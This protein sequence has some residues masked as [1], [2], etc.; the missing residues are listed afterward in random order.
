ML[1]RQGPSSYHRIEKKFIAPALKPWQKDL[2]RA[3]QQAGPKAGMIFTVKSMRQIGK[4]FVVNIILLYHALTYKKSNSI[5]VSITYRNCS[6]MFEEICEGLNGFQGLDNIDKMSMTIKFTNGS[7]ITYMSAMSRENLRG[8][9]VKNGGILCIDEAAYL[10]EDIFGIVFPFVNVSNANILMVSTPRLKQGSYYDYYQAGFDDSIE[11][12]KS[13]NWSTYD[14]SE[15][16]TPERVDMYRKLLPQSQFVSEVL[17][18]FVDDIAGVFDLKDVWYSAPKF[19]KSN[20][21]Q[22]IF[23]GI[24]WSSGKG[25]DFT[26]I[27]GFDAAGN[28]ILLEYFNDKSPE[29]QL[30]HISHLL[31]LLDKDKIRG[32]NCETNS[33]GN[34]Y[35]DRL[36]IIMPGF[37]IYEFTT[38]NSS[39]REIV[40][41]LASRCGE[42]TIRLI[43]DPEQ[44]AQMSAYQMQ[45]TKSGLTTYNSIGAHDDIC[46]A[47]SMAM[48]LIKDKLKTGGYSIRTAAP[49]KYINKLRT[50]YG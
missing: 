4:S 19:P 46:M 30:A 38:S 10:S 6:K 42:K 41:Y 22:D 27:S 7:T 17:G 11:K 20:S 23:I 15:L 26:A 36:K 31:S 16:L 14:V 37:P 9:T 44:Y 1:K 12:V 39:K 28:Q 2:F 18:E 45:I 13:F 40:E 43:D 3:I 21:Y 8:Y 5:L 47:N 35:I 34:I 49:K 25:Q 33:I 29:E 50:H 24:D 32:I 48:K